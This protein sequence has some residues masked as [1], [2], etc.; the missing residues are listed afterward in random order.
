MV[1]LR[2]LFVTDGQLFSSLVSAGSKDFP[3]TGGFHSGTE[4]VHF[5]MFSFLQLGYWHEQN[6]K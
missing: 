2:T 3:A 1:W 5:Q 4:T 6:G